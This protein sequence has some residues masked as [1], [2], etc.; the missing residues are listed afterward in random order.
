MDSMDFKRRLNFH[1]NISGL[2]K[3]LS[4]FKRIT[5]KFVIK[6]VI[7]NINY[8]YSFLGYSNVIVVDAFSNCYHDFIFPLA[9]LHST[10][11]HFRSSLL[12]DIYIQNFAVDM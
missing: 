3:I 7:Y 11:I 12:K 1:L 10:C 8:N 2:L 9:G 6:V 5:H 4:S